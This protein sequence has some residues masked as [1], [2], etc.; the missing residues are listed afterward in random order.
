MYDSNAYSGSQIVLAE[1]PTAL[2]P[3]TADERHGCSAIAA[4][5]GRPTRRTSSSGRRGSSAT[6]S[7][8]LNAHRA[9]VDAY[10]R[11]LEQQ[12]LSPASIARKLSAL[13][14]FY[15]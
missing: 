3:T 1:P 8:V 12:G 15:A 14:G 13:S 5:P 4:P 2:A 11:S 10:A 7:E 6:A 9:H